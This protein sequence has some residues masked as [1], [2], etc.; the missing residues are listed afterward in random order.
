MAR[1]RVRRSR[2]QS[3]DKT[4][5]AAFAV[6]AIG[7]AHWLIESGILPVIL[8]IGVVAACVYGLVLVI[9][10]LHTQR[11]ERPGYSLPVTESTAVNEYPEAH[12]PTTTAGE[13]VV[14]RQLRDTLSPEEYFVFDD[15]TIP[16][17]HNGSSQ[18]DHVV[19]SRFGI[20]V[21]ENKDWSG[22]IYG[23]KN[24]GKWTQTLAGGH[25]KSHLPNPLRQ[26][27]SHIQ[28]LRAALPTIPDS[29]FENVVAL[30]DEAGFKTE[31]IENVIFYSELTT[32]ILSFRTVRLTEEQ[33]YLA[34]GYLSHTN[35]TVPITPEEHIDNLENYLTSS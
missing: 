21:I 9:R 32:Y 17:Q 14:S 25:S 27:W 12:S 34:I 33:L 16:S 28:S 3:V 18:I 22:W 8:F 10:N 5:F 11:N 2:R 29:A 1:R 30:D 4:L 24:R 35:Q 31:P 13:R 26:N 15:V 20:F 7:T 6:V 19:V 23:S